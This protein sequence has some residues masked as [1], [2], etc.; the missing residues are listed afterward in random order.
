MPKKTSSKTTKPKKTTKKKST[1]AKKTTKKTTKKAKPKTKK[2]TKETK[3]VKPEVI[4][5]ED[6]LVE[7]EEPM[8]M[9]DEMDE[10]EE[11]HDELEDMSTEEEVEDMFADDDMD[12]ETAE[13]VEEDLAPVTKGEDIDMPKKKS[14]S[15]KLYRRIAI[16]FVVVTVV[17]LG[18]VLLLSTVKA[19]I[20]IVP[21]TES[22][23]TEFITDVVASP[24]EASDIPGR[25]LEVTVEQA[26]EFTVDADSEESGV[27][28]KAGG[29]VTIYNTSSIQQPLVATTRLLSEDGVLF[30]ID[31]SVVV[32]AGGSVDVMAHADE[33]GL[34]GEIDPT[35]FTIPGLNESRQEEVYAESTSAMTG[36]ME[37]VAVVSA[38]DLADAEEVLAAE[39]RTA[40]REELREILETTYN[41]EVWFDEITE[42]VSDTE[43]GT[44]TGKFTISLSMTVTG[45]FYDSEKLQSIAEGKLY[46]NLNQGYEL[47]SI[48]RDN[49][50]VTVEKYDAEEEVAN[51]RVSLDG[52]MIISPAN[53]LLDKD[54]FVGL[55]AVQINE[56]L[57]SEG[58][59]ASVEVNLFPFFLNKVPGLKDHIEIEV[60]EP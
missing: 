5:E 19:S 38:E 55:N 52:S 60:M 3:P 7:D 15:L 23:S 50:V 25:V 31:E 28:A 32:P 51:V 2:E 59:A 18:V 30:R 33:T 22:V 41:G 12:E 4:E 35:T 1:K 58:I 53:A 36:G 16:A 39:M 42:K 11:M 27:P 17:L 24:N 21:N 26:K 34:D 49:M 8:E 10:M 54:N 40:A 47:V 20:S 13:T 44:E 57:V 46:E 56:Q 14:P 43:P 9:E 48:D 6:V 37:Y 29:T 45:V